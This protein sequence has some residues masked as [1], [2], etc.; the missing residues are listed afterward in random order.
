MHYNADTL[1][2]YLHGEL[3]DQRDASIHAHLETCDGCRGIYN[4][5]AAIRDALRASPLAA[6]RELPPLLRAQVWEAIRTAPPTPLARLRSWW[7]PMLLVPVAA[8]MAI[9]VYVA[10]PGHIGSQPAMTAAYLFE[11]HAAGSAVSPLADRGLVVPA[12]TASEALP[13]N[14]LLID[15]AGDD[16]GR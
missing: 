9:F 11:E 3:D 8:V 16:T 1:D 14:G 2:D 5:I 7:R 4:E 10:S 6:E 12:S 15:E 13:V